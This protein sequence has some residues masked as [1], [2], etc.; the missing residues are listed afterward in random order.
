MDTSYNLLLGRPFVHMA[1]ASPSTLLQLM[2]FVL[3][4]Q[5]L[6]IHCEES[7]SGGHALI[8]DEVSQCIDFYT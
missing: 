1:G 5:E 6:V 4:E 2:K 8:I 7:H 3:K